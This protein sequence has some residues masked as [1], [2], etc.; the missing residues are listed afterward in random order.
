[1]KDVCYNIFKVNYLCWKKNPKFR[2]FFV[3]FWQKYKNHI[4]YKI[5][6]QEVQRVSFE[7][8]TGRLDIREPWAPITAAVTSV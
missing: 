1:M 6:F 4:F 5:I 3:H 7:N 8:L 2:L